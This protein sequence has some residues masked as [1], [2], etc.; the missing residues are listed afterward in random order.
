MLLDVYLLNTCCCQK[1][2]GSKSK[3]Q[4]RGLPCS[5]ESLAG[6][7]SWNQRVGLHFPALLAWVS[8]GNSG[9]GRRRIQAGC[10]ESTGLSSGLVKVVNNPL[11]WEGRSQE[12]ASAREVTLHEDG[13]PLTQP[14]RPSPWEGRRA[15]QGR[16]L[17]E[18][19]EGWGRRR[20]GRKS[21]GE[22]PGGET[23]E[24]LEG[25]G[26]RR[27][28]ARKGERDARRRQGGGGAWLKPGRSH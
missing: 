26:K 14:S 5:E 3:Y 12:R 19:K 24:K 7:R 13:R 11:V 6:T 15:H 2:Q 23:R 1:S 10:K 25:G 16:G 28:G 21:L 20:A 8:E 4:H 9:P 18:P 17:G 22:E 27:K